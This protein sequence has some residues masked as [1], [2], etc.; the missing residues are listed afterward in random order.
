MEDKYIEFILK[1]GDDFVKSKM[2][3]EHADYIFKTYK[4][5]KTNQFKDYPYSIEDEY[6]F[7]EIPCMKQ[8]QK[9]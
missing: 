9:N 1:S 8:S 4:H 6:F 3:E 5:K 2:L 7:K